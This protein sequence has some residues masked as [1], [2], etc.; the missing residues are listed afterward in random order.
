MAIVKHYELVQLIGRETMHV[1]KPCV[2]NYTQLQRRKSC[3]F[4]VTVHNN[5]KSSV[6]ICQLIHFVS[7]IYR[8]QRLNG[9][10][11]VSQLESQEICLSGWQLVWR[12]LAHKE[13]VSLGPL[14]GWSLPMFVGVH[15]RDASFQP[16]LLL[17]HSGDCPSNLHLQQR[18]VVCRAVVSQICFLNLPELNLEKLNNK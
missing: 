16:I 1:M 6:I 13:L 5:T 3:Y 8:S 10:I 12:P 7:N 2:P 18:L 4:L 17:I 9:G 11:V 15:R 14:P